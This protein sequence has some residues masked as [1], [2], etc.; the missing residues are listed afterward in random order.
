VPDLTDFD[1]TFDEAAPCSL[2]VGDDEIDF[3]K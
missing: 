3:A 1:P 2:K